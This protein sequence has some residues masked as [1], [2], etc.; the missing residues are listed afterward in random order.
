MALNN[1][2][3][4]Q[5]FGFS[6]SSRF[7]SLKQNTKNISASVFDKSSDFDRT[8]NFANAQTFAFGSR[9]QRFNGYNTS[10]KHSALPSPNNYYTQPRTFSPDV[11]RSNGWSVG[12]GRDT[13]KKMHIDLLQDD[14]TK[15]IS[16]PS[17]DSYEKDPTFGKQGQ[18][19]SMR[20]KM[21]RYGGRSDKFDDYN[22]EC[23]KK[24][25]GPG[26]Y[27]HPETVGTRMTSS[28]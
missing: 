9:Q 1:S 6:K 27:A 17:P 20:K 21:H 5:Q 3:S 13:M 15:K 14:A 10:A 8:K 28:V 2:S 25:P 16:S 18:H 19:F 12:L 22:F 23:E 24:L 11:S 26:F 4:K 7:P